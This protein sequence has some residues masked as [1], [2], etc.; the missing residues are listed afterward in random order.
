[1][2]DDAVTGGSGRDFLVGGAGNDTLTGGA[3]QDSLLGGG[4][5][6]TFVFNSCDTSP[7]S[8]VDFVAADDTIQLDAGVF[9]GLPAGVLAAESFALLSAAESADDRI[10]YDADTGNLFFDADGG[11]A[12]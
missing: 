6:D 3:G 4:G 7:D 2:G 12:R 10:L 5:A 9:Q 1:M 11:V 8:I